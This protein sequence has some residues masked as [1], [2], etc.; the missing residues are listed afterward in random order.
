MELT[1]TARSRYVWKVACGMV[2]KQEGNLE[3]YRSSPSAV[4]GPAASASPEMRFSGPAQTF[5]HSWGAP[6]I[7]ILTSRPGDCDAHTHV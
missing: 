3:S 1:P 7:C 4:L 2:T 6:S 5:R